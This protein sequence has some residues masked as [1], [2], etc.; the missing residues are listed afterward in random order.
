[1][2]ISAELVS[3]VLRDYNAEIQK[4]CTP[5]MIIQ[6]VAD[7]FNLTP[8]DIIGPRRDKPIVH[9]RHV[10]YY[11]CRELTDLS[12]KRIGDEFNG[13]DHATIINGIGKIRTAIKTDEEVRNAVEDITMRLRGE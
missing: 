13:R 12:N 6:T 3:K 8:E 7:Y 9:P 11:L 10:A 2:P 5:E 4:H 1:M